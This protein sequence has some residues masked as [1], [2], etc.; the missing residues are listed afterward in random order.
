MFLLRGGYLLTTKDKKF[1]PVE[2]IIL[3]NVQ[4]KEEF[5]FALKSKNIILRSNYCSLLCCYLMLSFNCNGIHPTKFANAS[6][7]SEGGELR[8]NTHNLSRWHICIC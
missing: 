3:Q 4:G 1:N 8:S 2:T 6:G 7:V 5:N